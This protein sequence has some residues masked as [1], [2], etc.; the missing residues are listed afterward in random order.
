[1]PIPPA[2]LAP[3]G[4]FVPQIFADPAGPAAILADAIDPKTGEYLSISRGM[5][6]VDQ[7]VLI[8]M[9]QRRNSGVALANDGN[10]FAKIRKVDESAA[11]LIDGETRRCLAK[12]VAR[13]DISVVGIYPNADPSNDWAEVAL[14]FQNLRSRGERRRV[15]SVKRTT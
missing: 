6:P 5:D 13:R 14:D 9:C 7:Q 15:A 2:G 3:A 8:A 10:E 1:M 4:L 11:R 12:L